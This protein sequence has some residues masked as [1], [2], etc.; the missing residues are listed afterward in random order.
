MPSPAAARARTGGNDHGRA[1][2]DNDFLAAVRATSTIGAT[3]KAGP[4]ATRDLDRNTGRGL[5]RSERHGLRGTSRQPQN[6]S[7]SDKLIH[8]FSPRMAMASW[9]HAA[10][11][12]AP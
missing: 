6:E 5:L 3:V 10:S 8:W 2:N 12:I 11:R 4:A 9:D 7:K 1:G